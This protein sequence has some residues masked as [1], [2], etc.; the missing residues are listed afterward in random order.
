MVGA[1]EAK[2]YQSISATTTV[3]SGGEIVL[4]MLERGDLSMMRGHLDSWNAT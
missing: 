4:A 1:G 3:I 2:N